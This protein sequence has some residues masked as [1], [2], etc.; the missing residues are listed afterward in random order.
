MTP[1]K[2]V[3]NSTAFKAVCSATAFVCFSAISC[4]VAVCVTTTGYF[5]LTDGLKISE[6]AYS[7]DG[8]LKAV[9]FS[10][11]RSDEKQ[12]SVLN[13]KAPVEKDR[14]GNVFSSSCKWVGA[15]WMNNQKLVIYVE[16]EAPRIREVEHFIAF[17]RDIDIDVQ[18]LKGK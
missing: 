3:F 4:V 7:P 12:V 5:W 11:P 1:L 18:D 10:L 16:G 15:K 17:D 14:A 13:S 9:V 6:T 8:K 2:V